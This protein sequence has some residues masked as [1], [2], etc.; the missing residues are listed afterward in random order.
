VLVVDDDLATREA[1]ADMLKEM[2]AQVRVADSAA[3]AMSVVGAFRPR[4]LLCDIAMPGEDGYTFIRKLRALGADGGGNTPALALTALGTDDDRRRSL[5]A[6]FQMHLTKPVDI[7]RLSRAVV[8]LS[9]RRDLGSP[10]EYPP[11]HDR[12]S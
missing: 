1:I 12:A 6:G 9:E 4:V 8:E 11:D 10:S 7:E 5:A 2:G 3:Q